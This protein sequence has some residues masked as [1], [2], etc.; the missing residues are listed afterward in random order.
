[1]LMI[2]SYAGGKTAHLGCFKDKLS[3]YES[4]TELIEGELV[5]LVNSMTVE[6][7]INRYVS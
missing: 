6:F 5:E 7:C 2:L 4:Q 3:K 1:M